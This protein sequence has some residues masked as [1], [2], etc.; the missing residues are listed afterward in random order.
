MPTNYIKKIIMDSKR[1]EYYLLLNNTYVFDNSRG[2]QEL[3]PSASWE[4]WGGSLGTKGNYE[5]QAIQE[6]QENQEV[7]ENQSRKLSNS[8]N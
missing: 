4:T 3:P 6:N 5:N 8:N 7:L 2:D 1:I